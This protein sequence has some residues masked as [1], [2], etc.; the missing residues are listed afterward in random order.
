MFW[1]PVFED[2]LLKQARK[3]IKW[4]IHIRSIFKL[5]ENNSEGMVWALNGFKKEYYMYVR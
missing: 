5:K 3:N 4:L 1:K 2:N